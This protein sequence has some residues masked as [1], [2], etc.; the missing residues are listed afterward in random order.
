MT[1]AKTALRRRSEVVVEVD[2]SEDPNTLD[3][4]MET[5]EQFLHDIHGTSSQENLPENEGIPSLQFL[6]EHFKTKSAAIRYL[7]ELG[8]PV[9]VIAKHLNI[10]YQHARNVLKTEL[11]R[12][13]N[14]PL[15][16]DLLSLGCGGIA[17]TILTSKDQN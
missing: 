5:L 17:Q 3:V 6:K 11:K 16:A 9:K 10:R 8:F 14:E 4:R 15:P 13:P 2:G 12:G 1:R 7:H